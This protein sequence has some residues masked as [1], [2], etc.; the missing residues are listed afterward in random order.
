MNSDKMNIA[1]S[2][3]PSPFNPDEFRKEGHKLVDSLS[4]YLAEALAGKKMAVLPWNE[5]EKLAD[6]FSFESGGGEL[7]PL[8]D[9]LKRVINYS[10]HLHHPNY[11]GHQVTSPLPVTVLAQFCTTLLNNG[12]AIYEMGPVNMAME[13]NVINML[14]LS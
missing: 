5:P 3:I 7:E 8:N 12:A 10:N 6:I 11:I 14:V 9:F 13:R 1:E 2:K 4:D